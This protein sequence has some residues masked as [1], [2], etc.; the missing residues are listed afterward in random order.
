MLR[1]MNSLLMPLTGA[2]AVYL[3]PRRHDEEGK[4]ID[5]TVMVLQEDPTTPLQVLTT[6]RFPS[7]STWQKSVPEYEDS[8]LN[9]V[10]SYR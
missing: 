4:V 3:I 10:G 2:V 5:V 1:T 9:R 6:Y 7:L 8:T